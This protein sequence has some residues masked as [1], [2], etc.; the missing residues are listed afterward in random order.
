[1]AKDFGALVGSANDKIFH[2]GINELRPNPHQP[3]KDFSIEGLEMLSDSIR[4]YGII[5]PLIVSK[6]K[7]YYQIITGERRWRAAK[8]LQL[9][10]V[11][12]IVREVKEHERLELA[13]IENI[14]RKNLNPIEEGY[15]Y[16]RLINEFNLTQDELAKR[17][18]KS[19]PV[20]TNTMRLL[21]L[22]QEIQKALI[23]EKIN[24]SQARFV[25]GL[26]QNEQMKFFHKILQNKVPAN[27]L[28]EEGRQVT[29]RRYRSRQ[30]DPGILSLEEKLEE[31]LST[32]VNIQKNGSQGKIVINFYSDEELYSLI[33]KISKK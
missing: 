15:A 10:T 30:K 32:K 20:I 29:L 33:E 19:R 7:D 23:D 16:Q 3:R 24:Y 26:P 17:I 27:I 8:M 6:E 21:L 12:A 14:Q 9:K 1:M 28:A 5:Q 2:I 25:A 18:G 31:T 22:P 11:P 13:L 4:Q